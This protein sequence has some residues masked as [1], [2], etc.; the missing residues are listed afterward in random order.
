VRRF[1]YPDIELTNSISCYR[2]AIP[3]DKVKSDPELSL[4]LN[5]LEFW[6]GPNRSTAFGASSDD[7]RLWMTLYHLGSTGVVGGWK[8]PGDMAEMRES[9]RDF[10][11]QI[12]KLLSF[13]NS[14]LVWKVVEVPP[15]PS[16]VSSKRKLVL[17]GDA[18]HAMTPHQGQVCFLLLKSTLF[19]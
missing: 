17:L 1:L 13:A 15:L 3:S 7:G 16:W 11:P 18:S 5:S 12:K 10:A 19:T 8:S 4:L 2:A 6:V 14:C 9:Y